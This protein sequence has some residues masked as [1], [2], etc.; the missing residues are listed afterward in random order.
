MATRFI[1]LACVVLS[2]VLLGRYWFMPAP[3]TASALLADTE[4]AITRAGYDFIARIDKEKLPNMP[5]AEGM[6]LFSSPAL[7]NA[8]G[9]LGP[10][11][12]L[13]LPVVIV[14][15]SKPDGTAELM[16]SGLSIDIWRPND[17]A[18]ALGITPIE[19]A[20]DSA[21]LP[22]T[23]PP[24]DAESDMA[25]AQFPGDTSFNATGERVTEL[26]DDI[27]G[28]NDTY[29]RRPIG[30][31]NKGNVQGNGAP[32]PAELFVIIK[33]AQ[34][35][36]AAVASLSAPVGVDCCHKV[37]VTE[38]PEGNIAVHVHTPVAGEDAVGQL[39]PPVCYQLDT[40]AIDNTQR[41][42]PTIPQTCAFDA[43]VWYVLR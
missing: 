17:K 39:E 14:V 35:N 16:A 34:P 18:A 32:G 19:L 30:G 29:W 3:M 38:G 1:I 28:G 8:L 11:S 22:A 31:P 10:L 23:L 5:D 6:L 12:L 20:V 21:A 41:I 4:Q 2:A 13:Q 42:V 27:L 7:E 15:S 24:T 43:G 37:L 26:I 25:P 33:G 36:D 40:A 9:A